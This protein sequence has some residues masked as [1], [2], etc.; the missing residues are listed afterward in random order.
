[1]LAIVIAGT[2]MCAAS[3]AGAEPKAATL[4]I[5]GPSSLTAVLQGSGNHRHA[6]L[7]VVVANT[8]DVATTLSASVVLDDS[9]TPGCSHQRLHA[10]IVGDATV[11]AHADQTTRVVIPVAESCVGRA[12]TLF[13]DGAPGVDPASARLTLT[14]TLGGTK[15]ALPTLI[16]ALLTIVSLF[17]LF[18]LTGGTWFLKAGRIA[19]GPGWTVQGSWLTNVGALGAILGTVLGATNYLADLVPGLQTAPFVGLN[20]V[21][22]A[23][24]VTAPIAYYAFSK[25]RADP[26]QPG[27]DATVT[28]GT[29][30]GVTV[31]MA[32][33]LFGVYGELA[34]IALLIHESTRPWYATTPLFVGLIASAVAAGAYAIRSTRDTVRVAINTNQPARLS[35]AA[36]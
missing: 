3:P 25:Q 23:V 7:T 4:S 20:L 10:R 11:A 16:A 19:I 18:R 35:G 5:V 9:T 33:T 29:G 21:F 24:V 31:L 26:T 30:K 22:G 1:M 36:L 14:R 15:I 2:V 6:T 32:V 17:L 8:G 13:I 12:G 27:T 28:I 34:T